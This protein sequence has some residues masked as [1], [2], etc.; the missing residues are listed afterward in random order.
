MRSDTLPRAG[1]VLRDGTD[2]DGPALARLIA[3]CFADYPGCLFDRAEFPELDRPA[4]HY[5][6]IPGRLIVATRDGTIVGSLAVFGC[7][8]PDVAEL[9]K[10]YVEP[11]LHG[12][13]L[14]GRLFAAGRDHAV[15]T[16]AREIR[17]WTDTRFVRGHGFYRKLGFVQM[18]GTRYLHDGSGSWEFPFRLGLR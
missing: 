17:L 18:P 8:E 6:A 15:T 12:S 4:S 2:N 5:A 7:Q 14:A 16:G 11:S 10:V 13:G 3:R 9:A 1:I